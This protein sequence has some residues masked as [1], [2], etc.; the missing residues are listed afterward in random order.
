M[1]RTLRVMDIKRGLVLSF[2][3]AVLATLAGPVAQAEVGV[4]LNLRYDD[5]ANES[6][7]G[8]WDMLVQSSATNGVSAVRVVLQGIT[9]V[10]GVD[11]PLSAII[12]NSLAFDNVNSLFRFQPFGG[13]GV[14]IVAG[15]DLSGTLIVGVGTGG[16]STG[17]IPEDDLFPDGI[18]GNNP[19]DNSAL[20]ASGTFGSARPQFLE[21]NPANGNLQ[22]GSGVRVLANEFTI[23]A[24][25]PI[26]AATIG[27]V[28]VRGDAAIDGSG[29]EEMLLGDANR[30]GTVN[31]N[32]FNT[33][34]NNLSTSGKSWDTG[35]V[36]G[37]STGDVN[38]ADVN[39]VLDNFFQSASNPSNLSASSA[40]PASLASGS[41]F[42]LSGEVV[43]AF[44]LG[45]N[46]VPLPDISQNV[47]TPLV[48]QIDFSIDT[49]GL[50][51]GELG[52]A[53]VGFNILPA[54][55]SDSL[56]IGWTPTTEE[57]DTNGP[58]AGGLAPLF[59]T[60]Q[61]AGTPDDFAGILA[62]IAGG[63]TEASDPRTQVGQNGST[64]VGSVFLEWD[65]VTQG[66]VSTEGVL[67]SANSL[68]GQFLNSQLGA[69]TSI[70]FGAI[71]EPNTFALAGLALVVLLAKVDI[72]RSRTS[73]NP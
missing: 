16:S 58:A 69:S 2:C 45:M 71:P 13:V 37:S 70:S 72:I 44:D 68:S 11:T 39:A 43:A 42:S 12:P 19:W 65:G 41:P 67:F 57:V 48:Y 49:S 28:S 36:D 17:N 62:S 26:N 64:L 47:G 60:N 34:I 51:I 61:D 54:N 21:V 59:A 4:Q 29:F 56:A 73:A 18:V 22:M 53:N 63:L 24:T 33:V 52:F 9:G 5:P 38:N 50:E 46:P 20:L 3:T 35:D 30:S 25:D 55:L 31:N 23:P 6:A 66:S 7:G 10:T 14:E 15:D 27:A 32:D 8:T 1:N 40:S